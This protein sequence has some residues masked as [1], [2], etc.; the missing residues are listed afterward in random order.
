[1]V[2]KKNKHDVILRTITEEKQGERYK[3]KTQQRD[4]TGG[5]QYTNDSFKSFHVLDNK[6]S[7]RRHA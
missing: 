1:M 7:K 4:L 3:R 5:E 2:K 6:K